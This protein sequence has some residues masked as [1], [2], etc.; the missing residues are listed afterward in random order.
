MTIEKERQEDKYRRRKNYIEGTKT[1]K[2]GSRLKMKGNKEKEEWRK[3]Q[4]KRAEAKNERK[5]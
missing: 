5:N 4:E 2:N 3:L 1:R